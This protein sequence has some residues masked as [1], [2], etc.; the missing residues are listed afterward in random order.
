[1]KFLPFL[2]QATA[3]AVKIGNDDAA[4]ARPLVQVR[5]DLS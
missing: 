5:R 1:M 3:A 4:S 2:C